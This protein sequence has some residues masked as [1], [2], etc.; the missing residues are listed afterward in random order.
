METFGTLLNQ[1]RLR[2]KDFKT[3]RKLSQERLTQ[4]LNDLLGLHYNRVSFRNWENDANKI[5]HN[6]RPLL[7]GLITVLHE[8]GGLT[9]LDAANTLLVAGDYRR[10]DE[11]ELRKVNPQWKMPTVPSV[12]TRT[13]AE[14]T[15][16]LPDNPQPLIDVADKIAL[17]SAAFVTKATSLV[18]LV[19]VAGSG[20][21]VLAVAVAHRVIET[22]TFERVLRVL[23]NP[24]EEDATAALI[25]ASARA[26]VGS[27]AISTLDEKATFVQSHL[28]QH[29][30]FVVVDGLDEV[31]D[32]LCVQ[33][34]AWTGPSC[35]LVTGRIRPISAPIPIQEMPIWDTGTAIQFVRQ[36]ITQR[37]YQRFEPDEALLIQLCEAVG[38]NPK[39]LQMIPELVRRRPPAQLLAALQQSVGLQALQTEMV[40]AAWE[41]IEDDAR[42][43]LTTLCFVTEAGASDELLESV[44]GLAERW[45]AM[46]V[47]ERYAFAIMH[48]ERVGWYH[49]HRLVARY[50]IAQNEPQQATIGAA[51]LAYW[52][53]RFDHLEPSAW[54]LLTSVQPTIFYA[55]QRC[56]GIRDE[57]VYDRLA[58]L[59]PTLYKFA[60]NWGYLRDLQ[61][62]LQAAVKLPFSA[63]VRCHLL[64]LLGMVQQQNYKWT[65]AVE[66]L[67][68]GYVLAVQL[69]D[70][71]RQAQAQWGLA[72]VLKGKGEPDSVDT[73]LQTALELYE[74]LDDA[75]GIGLSH[76]LRGVFE[77]ERGA[78]ASAESHFRTAIDKLSA[79]DRANAL[80]NLGVLLQKRQR[81]TE[82][83][84]AYT[85]ARELYAHHGS[86]TDQ[87]EVA[88]SEA[89]LHARQGALI[90]A[91][92]ILH[93]INIEA[94]PNIRLHGFYW[95]NWGRLAF[96]RQLW[97]D[98]R[99]RLQKS[100]EAWK[101]V[102][103]VSRLARVKRKLAQI[104]A[105]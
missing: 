27:E 58:M 73:H 95:W 41:L 5:H 82:A 88:I 45:Q 24:N 102:G 94:V 26:I 76:N 83:G 78:L 37:G 59:L 101:I 29:A 1:A 74:Q 55:V 11:N 18:V 21:S 35:F 12:T 10:L 65:E 89:A 90:E 2:S 44:S 14:Q 67:Q 49:T 48:A 31:T 13:P 7:V 40:A 56:L 91:D 92:T 23:L 22:R 79:A 98:A 17:I 68:T 38:G 52:Q 54:H 69:G 19:G 81:Y 42:T 53:R 75:Q 62:L 4:R 70:V 33:I 97:G 77:Y 47:L 61:P 30:Y 60:S 86:S 85:E 100:A 66:T 103:D 71:A 34:G 6:D 57:I 43:L 46:E 8:F 32:A 64:I 50:V 105:D 96:D 99:I 39:A 63:S 80:K 84:A 16:A 87:L 36:Q 28:R 72:N 9:D 25:E 20:K 15:A 104:K 93:A 51:M 3:N